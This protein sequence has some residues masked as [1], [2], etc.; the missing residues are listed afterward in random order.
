MNTSRFEHSLGCLSVV[1]RMVSNLSRSVDW[2]EYKKALGLSPDEIMQVAR[3]YGLLHDVGHLPLSHLFETA[4]SDFVRQT[5]RG[6]KVSEVCAEWF[7][8]AGYA[9]P[10][11]TLGAAVSEQI[12]DD[13][14][15]PGDTK[16]AVLRLL[17]H[18]TV[19]GNDEMSPLKQLVDSEIDADRI[20]STARD[21][22]LGGGEYGTYDIDRLCSAVFVLH[23]DSGWRIGYSN[24]AISSLEALLLDRCRTHANIHYHHRVVAIKI[25]M[26]EAISHMLG[27][28]TID[29]ASFAMDDLPLRDDVWLWNRIR[30]DQSLDASL[31]NALLYRDK[32]C[33]VPLWKSRATFQKMTQRLANA[34]NMRKGEK[35]ESD[36]FLR[37][38]EAYISKRLSRKTR[39]MM[40][41]FKPVD[42]S[43]IWLTDENGCEDAGELFDYSSMSTKLNAIW[44]GEP[45]FHVILLDTTPANRVDAI[46]DKWIKDTA[47]WITTPELR[48][49]SRTTPHRKPKVAPVTRKARG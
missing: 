38:Y 3:L 29:R 42:S 34:A 45:S 30:E 37:E 27:N 39:V 8:F 46:R 23:R 31:K 10:H 43:A 28:G 44:S 21:G 13:I 7:G 35:L 22:K 24:K 41:N 5:Q 20:D 19:S 36:W 14:E 2:V 18:K 47:K 15:V 32:R 33:I 11:E 40:L 4:F 17:Q 48:T 12:L 26:R 1:S 25:A 9:K 16:K 6:K 49:D